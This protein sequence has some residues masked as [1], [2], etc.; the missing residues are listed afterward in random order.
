VFCRLATISKTGYRI[1]ICFDTDKVVV[2]KARIKFSNLYP[3]I[4]TYLTFEAPHY[5]LRVGDF[6]TL[7]EAQAIK[8]SIF[9]KF[10]IT[11][12]QTDYVRPPQKN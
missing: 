8:N 7:A 12:I 1:Q 5:N 10:T 9:S 4:A 2:N 3:K 11:N 6:Q